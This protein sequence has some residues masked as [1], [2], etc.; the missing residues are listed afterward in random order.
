MSTVHRVHPTQHNARAL[1][2]GL[3]WLSLGLGLAELLAAGPLARLLGVPEQRGLLRACGLREL[4]TGIGLLTTDHP[5]PWIQA[6]LVGDA[7]DLA[8]LGWTVRNGNAPRPAALAIGMVA[9]VTAL[10]VTCAR[11]LAVEQRW[12][13]AWDYSDRTGF[14]D[15]AESMRGLAEPDATCARVHPNGYPMEIGPTL[16]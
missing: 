4:T 16:H 8:G 2:R 12:V 7:L 5:Q 11:G 14:P 10:D 15:T 9:G 3:G 1:A 13:N 6:R